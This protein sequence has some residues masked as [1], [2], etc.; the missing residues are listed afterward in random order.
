MTV[1]ETNWHELFEYRKGRLLWKQKTC[2]RVVAGRAAGSFGG[3]YIRIMISGKAHQAHR[4]IWEMFNGHIPPN[5][6]IDH[7]NHVGW[8]NRIENLRLVDGFENQQNRSK[9]KRNKSGVSGV[10]LR[11]DRNKWEVAITANGKRNFIGYYESFVD[12]CEARIIAEVS[13]GFHINHGC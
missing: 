2:K 1:I 6:Q 13:N 9:S 3:G 7:I 10:R 8:D 5:M 4:I 12:A 11:P